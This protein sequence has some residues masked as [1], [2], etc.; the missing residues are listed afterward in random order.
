V[1]RGALE[2]S[3]GIL[4]SGVGGLSVLSSFKRGAVPVTYFS[5]ASFFPYGEKMSGLVFDRVRAIVSWMHAR[6]ICRV[7]V[8]C[9][10]ASYVLRDVGMAGL[11][12]MVQSTI[13][14][15]LSKS[16]RNGVVVLCTPLS[17]QYGHLLEKELR[18][19]G[20]MLPIFFVPCSGLA[21]LIE[22]R[23]WKEAVSLFGACLDSVQHPFDGVVYGCTHYAL[24]GP[25]L[26]GPV[27]DLMIDPAQYVMNALEGDACQGNKGNLSGQS[28]RQPEVS[29]Y[30]TKKNSFLG[31]HLEGGHSVIHVS[32]EELAHYF[33]DR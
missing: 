1:L 22:A 32:E 30:C 33:S 3:I 26:S 11:Y 16:I 20:F 13:S 25:H 31:H 29:F 23:C 28:I 10:T 14:G 27:K 6:G 2:V 24:L 19:R 18:C 15:I 9:H 12:D 4:D 21:G 8:G 17:A 5:D 7:I